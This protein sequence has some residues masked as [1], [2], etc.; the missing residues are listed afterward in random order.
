[1]KDIYIYLLL[2]FFYYIQLISL[3]SELLSYTEL[4]DAEQSFIELYSFT[5]TVRIY[6]NKRLA[7][8][9]GLVSCDGAI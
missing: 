1:M 8:K 6:N 2:H 5:L 7:G 3:F 9:I 4:A